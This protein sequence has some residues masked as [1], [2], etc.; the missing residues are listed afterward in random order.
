MRPLLGGSTRRE[1]PDAPGGRGPRC[2][3]GPGAPPPAD[4]PR[5][6]AR[7]RRP[8]P[9]DAPKHS[10]HL[11]CTILPRSR[12]NGAAGARARYRGRVP[13]G[14]ATGRR[15]RL[16][17]CKC[18]R[19]AA[20][21]AA[22]GMRHRGGAARRACRPPAPSSARRAASP[23]RAADAGPPV[24]RTGPRRP[25]KPAARHPLSDRAPRAARRPPRTAP[26]AP[27]PGQATGGRAAG[28]CLPRRGPLQPLV[29]SV[30]TRARSRRKGRGESRA[31]GGAAR[32]LVDEVQQLCAQQVVLPG[33]AGGWVGGWGG[34]ARREWPGGG[35]KGPAPP[36]RPPRAPAQP[37]LLPT[38]PPSAAHLL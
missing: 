3:P 1:R 19:Q 10:A 7:P 25:P 29:S 34:E 33:G 38:I 15:A 6:C 18:M 28:P 4:G 2:P 5:S 27:P 11:K 37:P 26:R 24:A 32:S 9:N 35:A 13:L 30:Y 12:G 36:L 8:A 20:R 23:R 16:R 21:R 14:R 22:S 17:G 31:R